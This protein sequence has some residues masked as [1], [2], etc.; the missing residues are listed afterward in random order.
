MGR[1]RV[2]YAVLIVQKQIGD[3][4]NTGP[5]SRFSGDFSLF[6][7]RDKLVDLHEWKLGS[8]CW[9][10]TAQFPNPSLDLSTSLTIWTL[11]QLFTDEKTIPFYVCSILESKSILCFLPHQ[12]CCEA[13]KMST[14]VLQMKC[15]RNWGSG[16]C[17]VCSEGHPFK[18]YA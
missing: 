14:L 3:H 17:W 10:L 6:C 2:R 5:G 4:M 11:S 18:R 9:Y 12:Q 1:G 13:G 16:C 15:L 7:Q 8:L